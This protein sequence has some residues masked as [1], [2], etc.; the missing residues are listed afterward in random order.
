MYQISEAQVIRN[1]FSIIPY[2]WIRSDKPNKSICIMLPGLGYTT[3]RPLF[4]YATGLFLN[5]QVDVLQ[6]NYQFTKNERFKELPDAD[7][8][9]WMY[10]DVKVVVVEVLKNTNY[11]QF[12]IFGKSIG[13]IPMAKEWSEKGF[14]QNAVG[15]WLTPLVKIDN[16]YEALLNADHPSLCVIGDMDHHFNE[17]KVSTLKNNPLVYTFIVPDADHSLEIGGDIFASIEALKEVMKRVEDFM[18]RYKP[19]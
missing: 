7:Q 5:H 17:E 6:I 9:Q 2:T 14:V 1:E 4:D 8:T 12:F 15:I 11:E 13:S 10:D 16:A 19:Y 18:M 3:Q